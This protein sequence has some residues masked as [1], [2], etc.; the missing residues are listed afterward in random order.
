MCRICSVELKGSDRLVPACSTPANAGM[1][2]ETDSPVVR[3]TRKAILGMIVA[4]GRHDC[5]LRKLPEKN[6]PEYQKAS[7][8]RLHREHPCPAEGR[9]DLQKLVLDYGVPVKDLAPE[10]NEFLLDNFHPHDHA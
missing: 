8:A 2:I 9:C 4:K 1:E 7:S 6:W 10:P 5:F 3:A